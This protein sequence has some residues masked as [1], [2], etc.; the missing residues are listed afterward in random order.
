[1][2]SP[3]RNENSLATDGIGP[4]YVYLLVDPERDEIFYVGKGTGLRFAAPLEQQIVGD[5]PS[6]EELSAQRD[7]IDAIRAR[8]AEPVIEFARRQIEHEHEAYLIAAVL[9]DVL[10]RHGAPNLANLVR[11]RETGVLTFA[12]LR[13]QLATPIL[14]TTRKALL[15]RLGPWVDQPDEE[16]PRPGHGYRPAMTDSALYDSTR[17]WW[18][19]SL[20]VAHAYA[21]AVCVYEGVTRAVWKI[22]HDRWRRSTTGQHAGRLC[23]EGRRVEAGE[24]AYAEFIGKRGRRVPATRPDGRAVFGSGSPIAYWP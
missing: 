22:D 14:S 10:A 23:F 6:R 15:I 13:K 7:R 20:K 11:A 5:D 21:Y 24:Q 12:D 2:S 4:F 18:R 1:M 17:A 16:L 19:I 9:I 8:G 3:E